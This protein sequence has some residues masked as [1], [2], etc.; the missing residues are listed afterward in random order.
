MLPGWAA[1]EGNIDHAEATDGTLKILYSVPE[2]PDGAEPDLDSLK[3]TVNGTALDAEATLAATADAQ[4][5]VRRTSIL[6][7]DTSNSMRGERFDQ[8]KAAAKAFLDGSTRRRL[9]RDRGVRRERRRG[10]AAHPRPQRRP[11]ASSTA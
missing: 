1:G 11:R 10:A 5:Q 4:D 9:R 2:L 6:A 8:A 3:V 7:I